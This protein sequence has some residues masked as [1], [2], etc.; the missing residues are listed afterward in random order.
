MDCPACSSDNV[1][2]SGRQI[3]H[4]TEHYMGGEVNDYETDDWSQ[5]LG[6]WQWQCA[7]CGQQWSHVANTQAQ[8]IG[9]GIAK[10]HDALAY[11]DTETLKACLEAIQLYAVDL[12]YCPYRHEEG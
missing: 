8:W 12:G 1:T 3:A 11:G 2:G 4:I 6:R 10:A 5:R 9:D 7:D